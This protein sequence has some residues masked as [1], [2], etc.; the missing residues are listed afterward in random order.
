MDFAE[1]A[2][3][4]RAC[5]LGKNIGG[6]LGMPFE[7][8][9]GVFEVDY[10]PESVLGKG[11]IAND[12]LEL[13]LVFLNAAEKYG[14]AL[15]SAI[16]GEYWLSCIIATIS[17][18]GAGM[19]NMRMGI[20]P[21]FSG[22]YGNHN[23]DSCGSFIR[24]ELWACLT[25]GHPEL[26]AR[27]AFMDASVDHA[28]EGVY[29]EIFCSV[30]QSAAFVED[31]RFKLIDIGLSYIPDDCGIARGVKCVVECW[32]CGLDWKQ[33]RVK[34][35]NAVPCSFGMYSGYQGRPA[36]PDVPVG[37]LG[38]DGPAN[39]G[40]AILGLV[41]GEGDFSKSICIAAGCGED[42]DCTTATVGAIMGIIGGTASIPE[43]WT[44][45]LGDGIAIGCIIHDGSVT[46]PATV[47]E[48]CSR[49]CRLV[50]V[51]LRSPRESIRSMNYYTVSET[52][53][54][55]IITRGKG[56]LA[57]RKE[58][59]GIFERKETKFHYERQPY[60][61]KESN[62]LYEATLDTV[63]GI[64]IHEGVQK[65][66]VLEFNNKRITQHWVTVKWNLPAGWEVSPGRETAVFL[67]QQHGGTRI[68]ERVYWITP[69]NLDT[70]R[71]E[72][73]VEIWTNSRVSTLFFPL[74]LVVD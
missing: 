37:P 18:Y 48:L 57:D 65:K 55:G 67:D 46:Y 41:Y 64:S 52:G 40:I 24:S 17:E 23:K 26:A 29:G 27:Y 33:A 39:V 35:L 56:E 22:Y 45:P 69:R 8:K 51:F 62:T 21:P 38:Y 5:W 25:P 15:N 14:Q 72:I 3:K 9:R 6:T 61:I 44:Q 11:P 19:T 70:S 73:S 28:D 10:Y 13:Q 74:T 49:I 2:D 36:E 63:D 12:D 20:P 59:Y 58:Y 50:P 60:A 32:R 16:L 1:Y 42:G 31:D 43:K 47:T 30:V 54:I 4:V 53:Q 34:L 66:F 68:T 7:C 71:V